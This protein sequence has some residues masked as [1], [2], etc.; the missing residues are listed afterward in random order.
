MNFK[1]PVDDILFSLRHLAGAR[2][3]PD[4]ED[5][6]AEDLL[7][8]F[9]ELAEQIIAPLNG[10]GD[11]QGA[12]LEQGRV[13]LP[14]GFVAAYKAIK[15]GGWQG[16][17]VAERF[18]G[19]GAS[20]L[21]GAGIS[22]IFTAANQAMQMLFA[23]APGAIRTLEQFGTPTQ[24]ET[25]I[26]RL[27]SGEWL[28]T[29]C[30]TESHAGSDL[31]AIQ[32]T[33]RRDGGGWRIDGE[34]IFISGGDQNL[35]DGILHVILARSGSQADGIKGLS[36]FLAP[37]GSGVQVI[38]LE[39]KLGIKASPTCHL[40]FENL[41]AELV[42]QEGDGLKAMFA[43][44]NFA[45]IDVA[46]QGVGQA[47]RAAQLAR[48]YA[49]DRRQGRQS[50]G[51]PA[52]L[53]DHADIKRMLSE[54]DLLA[55]TARALSHLAMVEV[56]KKKKSVLVDVLTP[57]C[58]VYGSE[59]AIRC[60]DL[61]IQVMGGAGYL[62]DYPMEQIWRDARA[63]AIYEGANGLHKRT[64]VTRTLRQGADAFLAWIAELAEGN[65]RLLTMIDAFQD[66]RE[67]LI[68]CADPTPHAQDFYAATTTLFE[69]TLRLRLTSVACQHSDPHRF[70]GLVP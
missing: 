20:P 46:L 27:A 50:D 22:E 15:A 10:S 62:R 3:L 39:D 13:H 28:S 54:Q 6:L 70:D 69:S 19:A 47:A 64:L 60:A 21:I 23:L 26:P 49:R 5:A 35:S 7:R 68:V 16:L 45:R 55:V 17:S 44:M 11:R 48:D 29:M 14:D 43:M 36:L 38:R 4:W 34:K 58:K 40:V 30:L 18:G 57:L 61:G 51:C 37:S 53:S 63:T 25:W 41:R 12:R 9:A 59:A 33:A 2:R 1:A 65:D 66:L 56:E 31:S 8:H 32:T 67:S 52:M 42:G 24:Q